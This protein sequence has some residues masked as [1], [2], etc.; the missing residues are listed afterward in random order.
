MNLHAQINDEIILVWKF[1]TNMNE[2]LLLFAR[3]A[4]NLF[5]LTNDIIWLLK[6][7][8][9]LDILFP[10]TQFYQSFTQVDD[11]HTKARRE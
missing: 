5:P 7:S 6:F 11:I 1:L 8:K 3:R 2:L 4:T 9:C 10:F